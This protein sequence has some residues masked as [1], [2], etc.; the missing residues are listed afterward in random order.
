MNGGHSDTGD[1]SRPKPFF[2][3]WVN[4]LSD[5]SYQGLPIITVLRTRAVRVSSLDVNLDP[6][7]SMLTIS[8]FDLPPS[9][10]QVV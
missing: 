10:R 6:L 5:L 1:T 9:R 2:W 3:S 7:S 8:H 4:H